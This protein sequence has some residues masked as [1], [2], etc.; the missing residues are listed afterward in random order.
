MG[1]FFFILHGSCEQVGNERAMVIWQPKSNCI[2]YLHS[3]TSEQSMSCRLQ[4]LRDSQHLHLANIPK[5]VS[6]SLFF[7]GT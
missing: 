6:R 3:A 7:R 2:F 1:V 5:K 4:L